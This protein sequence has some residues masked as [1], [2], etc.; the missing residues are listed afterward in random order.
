MLIH[1]SESLKEVEKFDFI[2]A[3]RGWA[4]LA[5]LSV[6]VDQ[7]LLPN[8]FSPLAK[9]GALG[10][11]LFLSFLHSRCS[12][13]FISGV[14]KKTPS[15]LSGSDVF[16]GSRPCSGRP[17][18]FIFR[19]GDSRVCT[20]FRMRSRQRGSF[21]PFFRE[22]LASFHDQQC[23]PGRLDHRGGDEFLRVATAF[24]Q[25]CLKSEEGAFLL[26]PP[27]RFPHRGQ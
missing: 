21:R 11:Q 2:D 8:F 26:D 14:K 16:S 22:C 1:G 24:F 19:F 6:H 4:F 7:W 18:F 20:V 3:L 10:V 17:F 9:H 13:L 25:G 15:R 27:A 23:G 12:F 5:V